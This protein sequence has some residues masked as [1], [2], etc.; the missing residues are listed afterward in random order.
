MSQLL[1]RQAKLS[2]PARVL[3][4]E[5]TVWKENKTFLPASKEHKVKFMQVEIQLPPHK[6]FT[7]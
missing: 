2:S 4:K 7:H 1:L 3:Q 5:D 6:P